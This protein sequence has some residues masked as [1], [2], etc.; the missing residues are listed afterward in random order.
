MVALTDSNPIVNLLGSITASA[1]GGTRPSH[2]TGIQT[3]QTDSTAF[4]TG[5]YLYSHSYRSQ[6]VQQPLASIYSTIV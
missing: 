1:S 6:G 2:I 5:N 4:V 3:V